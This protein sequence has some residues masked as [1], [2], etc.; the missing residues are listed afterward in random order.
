MTQFQ[1][2]GK[3][4]KH[5]DTKTQR[6]NY[7]TSF[8]MRQVVFTLSVFTTLCLCVESLL[9][10]QDALIITTQRKGNFH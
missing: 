2:R 7:G 6:N 8:M 1:V 4:L 10:Y 3:T 5:K 9:Y